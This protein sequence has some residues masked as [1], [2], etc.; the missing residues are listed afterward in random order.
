MT[1]EH[2]ISLQPGTVIAGRYEVVKC[3]GAG[4]MGLVYACRHRELA[5]HLVA[6]KVLFPEVSQDRVA[7][8]RFRNEI[9]ASYGVSHPNVVRAYEYIRDGDLVAYTMEYVGGG[10]LADRLSRS[11]ELMQIPEIIKVLDQMCNGVQA[12]HDSG[13]VHRDLKPENILLTK[14]GDVKIADFGIARTGHGPKL[15]EHGGV[16]GTIDY[17][18]PEYILNSQVDWRSDIYAIGILGYEMLTGDSP[19][20]GDSV[21]ATMTKRLKTDPEVPSK[22]RQDCPPEL[23]AIILKAMKR[24][25]EARYQSASAMH[26][27][28]EPLLQKFGSQGSSTTQYKT[29]QGKGRRLTSVPDASDE[30]ATQP[31]K[32]RTIIN[33]PQTSNL[34]SRGKSGSGRV[35]RQNARD[36]ASFMTLRTEESIRHERRNAFPWEKPQ[37]AA[38]INTSS[39][40]GFSSQPIV[41][42]EATVSYTSKLQSVDETVEDA[43]ENDTAIITEKRGIDGVMGRM[44]RATDT[45]VLSTTIDTERMRKLHE[46]VDRSQ[47]W[48]LVDFLRLT[49]AVLFGLCVGLLIVNYVSEDVFGEKGIMSSVLSAQSGERE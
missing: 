17:V 28:L 27:D 42:A 29:T 34:E 32:P 2:L 36:S 46:L 31:V 20:R 22:I 8:A 41:G 25:P 30:D 5:G 7:A 10:D 15:T 3:L 18:S 13:I 44:D 37:Q 11:R 6:V 24:D 26:F 19:F 9:F 12:I 35:V 23:D 16:V 47:P 21:Y 48:D 49:L 38:R 4:S 1:E 45:H 33:Q 40:L 14:E 43:V 39:R